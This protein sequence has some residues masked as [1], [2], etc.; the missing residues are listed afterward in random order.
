MTV[1]EAG[2]I[3]PKVRAGILVLAVA[4]FASVVGAAFLTLRTPGDTGENLGFALVFLVFVSLYSVSGGLIA[5]RHPN[6]PLGWL[7]LGVSV[8]FALALLSDGVAKYYLRGPGAGPL[9]AR[10]AAAYEDYC[11][12]PLLL[13]PGL[14]VPLLFPDGRLPSAARRWRLLS[15]LGAI[16]IAGVTLGTA[17]SPGA[18]TEN[19][20]VINPLGSEVLQHATF[21]GILTPVAL[22]GALVAAAVRLRRS[23]GVERLQMRWL[24][25]AG[26][27][28]ALTAFSSPIAAIGK[29]GDAIVNALVLLGLGSVPVATTVAILRYRLYDIDVIVNRA[30]VYGSLTALLGGAYVGLVIAVQAV[31]PAGSDIG[32]ALSTLVVAALFRPLRGRVQSAVNRRFYRSRYDA[33]AAVEAFRQRLRQ[34]V[35]LDSV[36]GD[37]LTVVHRTLQPAAAFLWLRS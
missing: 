34:D 17:T 2:S 19:P 7:F 14:Y 23:R 29:P 6:N 22:V 12:F 28:L 27:F 10:L 33:V 20:G 30:L 31:L 3:A 16:G 15:W 5:R 25:T 1:T 21:L 32:V 9:G 26:G 24:M 13:T 8:V 4:A 35:D 11:W 36:G 18:L 37:L